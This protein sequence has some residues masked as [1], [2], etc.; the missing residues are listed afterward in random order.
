LS[1]RLEIEARLFDHQNEAATGLFVSL[2]RPSLTRLMKTKEDTAACLSIFNKAAALHRLDGDVE[3]FGMLIDVF[4]QDSV[5]LQ[6]QLAQAIEAG[7]PREAERSAHSLKGLASNFDAHAARDSAFVA[8]QAAR[9][10]DLLQVAAALPTIDAHFQRLREALR[11]CRS[12][13]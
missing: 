13:C 5:E 2:E 9:N 4:L 7:N 12:V 8:E 6:A 10:L 3:L 1:L 11:E